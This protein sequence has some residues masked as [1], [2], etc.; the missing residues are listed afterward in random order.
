MDLGLPVLDR[1]LLDGSENPHAGIVHQNVQA[2]KSIRCLLD[3][4]TTVLGT[5][6]VGSD[7]YHPSAGIGVQLRRDALEVG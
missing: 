2:A 4:A 5:G 1:E 6:H 7:T 3:K